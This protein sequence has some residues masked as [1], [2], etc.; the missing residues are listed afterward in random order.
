ML[1]K[2][3]YDCKRVLSKLELTLIVLRRI[4]LNRFST[5]DHQVLC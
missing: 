1:V 4:S 2:A 3:I 5:F